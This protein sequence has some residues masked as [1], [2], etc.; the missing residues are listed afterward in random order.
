MKDIPD[1]DDRG[2]RYGDG[3]FETV[4]VDRDGPRF[5]DRHIR[6]FTRGAER[7]GYPD[8]V[9]E[10]AVERLESLRDEQAGLWRLT[11]T[12]PGDDVRGG[13]SGAMTLQRRPL[14][15]TPKDET[16]TISV[17]ENSYFPADELAEYKTTSRIRHVDARRRVRQKGFDEALLV[18]PE[19][20]IGEATTANVFVRIG[21]GWVTPPIEGILPGVIRG[22]LL[23]RAA[24]F[25]EPVEERP[26]FVG[27]LQTCESVA[28][29]SSGRIVKPVEAVDDQSLETGPVEELRRL[30]DGARQSDE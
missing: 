1:A 3:L 18:S 9:V 22:V 4:R 21:G 15:E 8:E 24:E 12:R 20:R 10:R 25:G 29:T 11:V 5:L 26:I 27:D 16:A 19:G 17:V 13:G 30:F 2:F 28:L 6:R 23:E 7:L 14:P